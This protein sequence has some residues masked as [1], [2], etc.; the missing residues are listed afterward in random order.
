[1]QKSAIFWAEILEI[2]RHAKDKA[3]P[4]ALLEIVGSSGSWLI[5]YATTVAVSMDSGM[6]RRARRR[7]LIS[8]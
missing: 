1:M 3:M 7:A 5:I 8:R 6:S 2:L 4:R